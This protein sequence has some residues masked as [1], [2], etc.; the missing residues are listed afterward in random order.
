MQFFCKGDLGLY[1]VYFPF[2]ALWLCLAAYF[3]VFLFSFFTPSHAVH[4]H[5]HPHTTGKC[6]CHN[7]W[8][9]EFCNVPPAT[10]KQC[11]DGFSGAECQICYEDAYAGECR[12]ACDMISSC[13][14]HGRCIGNS[15]RCK[16]HARFEGANCSKP[17]ASH[18]G[19]TVPGSPVI[20]AIDEIPNAGGLRIQWFQVRRGMIFLP[21]SSAVFC[22]HCRCFVGVGMGDV[23]GRAREKAK[24]RHV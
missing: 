14:G 16:C 9:G 22:L 21:E 8:D 20:I 19:T 12:H 2:L 7:G 4:A 23:G 6:K 18:G 15:G 10:P 17:I 11:P 24:V 1:C 13:S 3:L 5:S